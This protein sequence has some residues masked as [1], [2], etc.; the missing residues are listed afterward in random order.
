MQYIKETRIKNERF[1]S[2]F[3]LY[4]YDFITEKGKT[5]QRR[6]SIVF[7]PVLRRRDQNAKDILF[8][9][10]IGSRGNRCQKGCDPLHVS[11]KA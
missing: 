8:R 4:E 5:I 7:F 3:L 1:L 2:G 6:F 11:G 9:R 10:R